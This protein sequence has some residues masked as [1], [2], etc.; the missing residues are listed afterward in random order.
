LVER[1]S[2]KQEVIGSSP[3]WKRFFARNLIGKM[4]I[5][6]VR[7]AGSSPAGSKKYFEFIF[8]FFKNNEKIEKNLFSVLRF[9]F[10][11]NKSL[12]LALMNA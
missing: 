1:L 8:A 3:I 7:V 12:I 11:I 2:D 10:T 4:L 5:L 6:H 9:I